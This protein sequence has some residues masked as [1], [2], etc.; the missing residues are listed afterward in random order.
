MPRIPV[1]TDLPIHFASTFVEADWND[2]ER[3]TLVLVPDSSGWNDFLTHFRAFMHFVGFAERY[4]VLELRVMFPGESSTAS[5]L[6][7]VLAGR[8]HA[9]VDEVE[10]P[11]VSILANTAGYR[12]LVARLGFNDAFAALR[13]MRDIVV[14]ELEGVDHETMSLA[15][16]LD[17]TQGVLR[18]DDTWAAFRQGGRYL[19][20]HGAPDVDDAAHSFEVRVR[21]EGI[22]GRHTLDADF[23]V[24]FPLSRRALVLVG[25]NGV[26]KTRLLHAMI[27]GL[28][29]APAWAPDMD[30]PMAS[31]S[32]RPRFSR[33]LVFSSTTS[34]PYPVSVLPWRGLDYRFHRM[35]G[36]PPGA[37][38]I[39]ARSLLDIDR[40]E[41]EVES[42]GGR[43]GVDLLR[44]M[45]DPLGITDNLHVEVTAAD[46]T[47]TLPEPTHVGDRLGLTPFGRSG[48][49]VSRPV[50][51]GSGQ[52]DW[53]DHDEQQE[54]SHSGAGRP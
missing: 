43:R 22:P 1:D 46:G 19:T 31:F 3:P 37:G 35:L 14:V 36:T 25:E 48:G 29:I 44:E 7:Q 28:Q 8:S 41:G 50:A 45:L 27:G 9:A 15:Q 5:K 40:S 34:D 21:L 51:R 24:D 18:E 11:F 38:D 26:G 54:A 12:T 6:V 20:P 32:P 13:R 30:A 2:V 4:A 39:L 52:G 23:G 47:D 17:F 16:G 10:Q 42:L 33:L 49:C 53:S